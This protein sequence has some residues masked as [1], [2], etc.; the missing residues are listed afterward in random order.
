[1]SV[2]LLKNP[3]RQTSQAEIVGQ[4]AKHLEGD[5]SHI[6]K[7]KD[8]PDLDVRLLLQEYDQLRTVLLS[9]SKQLLATYNELTLEA[10]QRFGPESN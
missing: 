3:R 9:V 2:T 1:M 8:V 10:N 5:F 6:F 4:A 7:L